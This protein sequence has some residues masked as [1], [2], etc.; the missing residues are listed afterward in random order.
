MAYNRVN[1]Q[2]RTK[3]SDGYVTIDGTNYPV[4]PPVY[5]GTTPCNP[6]R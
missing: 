5:T 2:S 3:I 4:T 1:W 6:T